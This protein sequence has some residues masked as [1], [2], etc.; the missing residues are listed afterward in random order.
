MAFGHRRDISSHKRL[1]LKTDNSAY[2]KKEMYITITGTIEKVIPG[3]PV[4]LQIFFEKI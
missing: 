3:M 4:T 1:K 2:G